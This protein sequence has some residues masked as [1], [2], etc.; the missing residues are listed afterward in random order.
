M[1]NCID[2]AAAM[3]SPSAY[4]PIWAKRKKTEAIARHFF[5]ESAARLMGTGPSPDLKRRVS[6]APK[7]HGDSEAL[8]EQHI[9][10]NAAGAVFPYER[11]ARRAIK[12][13]L[14]DG[15]GQYA[16]Q[17]EDEP[18]PKCLMDML[19]AM[20]ALDLLHSFDTRPVRW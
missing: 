2:Y 16:V 9:K 20:E 13:S 8:L 11:E 18:V 3:S 12:S 14:A 15:M 1:T 4:R 6:S 17:G 19:D 5:R 7:S 10:T